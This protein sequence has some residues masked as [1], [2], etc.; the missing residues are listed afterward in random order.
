MSI[1]LRQLSAFIAVAQLRSFSKAA[2]ELN[3]SQPA[4]S[5]RVRELEFALGLKLFGRTTRSVEPTAA[6]EQL[7]SRANRALGELD[8]VIQELRDH[9]SL[10][11]G[12]VTI[13]CLPAVAQQL[14]P[15][16]I[17]RF[18]TA[19]PGLTV[20][21]AEYTSA[22]IADKVL[23]GSVDFGVCGRTAP[24]S[25]LDLE[26]IVRDPFVAVTP[27]DHPLTRRRSVT[28]SVLNRYPL[29]A[30]RQGSNVRSEL[31]AAFAACGLKLQ[32]AYETTHHFSVLGMVEAGLGV[33]ALPSMT[34]PTLVHSNIGVVKLAASNSVVREIGIATKHG[35]APSPA[36]LELMQCIR[37][38]VV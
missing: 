1:S 19:H 8:A 22:E 34:V 29:I 38:L 13:A 26:L 4:L 18:V 33:G 31:E 11:R 7:L 10:Q 27:L 6:G 21:F 20:E 24:Q 14:V 3:L 2:E 30:M 25:D 36:A 12:R 28:L 35:S 15:R 23:E 32:P 16:A 17:K 5:A 37:Q 9:A